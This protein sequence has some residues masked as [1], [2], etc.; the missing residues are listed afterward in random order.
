MTQRMTIRFIAFPQPR[1]QQLTRS[2]WASLSVDQVTVNR[3]RRTRWSAPGRCSRTTWKPPDLADSTTTRTSSASALGCIPRKTPWR[4]FGFSSP[5]PSVAIRATRVA[6][7]CSRI[8]KRPAR[9]ERQRAEQSNTG[10]RAAVLRRRE[11]TRFSSLSDDEVS[12]YKARSARSERQRAEQSNTG[13]RAA[14]LRRREATRFSSLSDDEVGGYKARSARSE[15]QRAEQSNTAIKYADGRRLW[16][17]VR[18]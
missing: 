14:V 16:P 1:P 10:S 18:R 2:R 6:L 5:H 9:S 11:A 3:L 12:G 17:A 13:S 4:W 8:M 7:H 15:R